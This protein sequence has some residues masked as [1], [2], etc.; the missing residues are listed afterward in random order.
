MLQQTNISVKHFELAEAQYAT[1]RFHLMDVVF[2]RW[3]SLVQETLYEKMGLMFEVSAENVEQL[4]FEYFFSSVSEQPI[5][6]FE[7]LNKGKGLL[8]VENSF[9]TEFVLKNNAGQETNSSSLAQ[10][11]REHQK[12]LLDLMRLMI[13]DFE[14]SWLNIAEV[15]L[16]LNRVTIYPHRA[17]VMLPY[18]YCLVGCIN[19]SAG[20]ILSKIT[21]C[22]PLT[23]MDSLFKPLEKKKIIEPESMEYY[24]P[25]VKQHYTDFL[26]KMEYSVVA[27]LGSTD[28]SV[29][30]GKLEEGQVIPLENKDGL[31]TIRINGSPVLQGTTGVSDGNYSVSVIRGTEDKKPSAIQ[32][33][34][35]FKQVAWPDQ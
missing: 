27:E 22:L 10:L 30:N 25:H 28:L 16:N 17:R 13:G 21:L 1:G 20:D 23:G 19:I 34:R 11:M 3:S 7:T 26:D 2:R 24:F 29:T 35:E 32:Q 8:L 4:R 15:E 12:S 31:V 14:K 18:E 33:K 6:I 5:Y 9:F